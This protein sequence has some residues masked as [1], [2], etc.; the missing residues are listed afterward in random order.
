M[1]LPTRLPNEQMQQQWKSQLDPVLAIPMLQ[2]LQ[3]KGVALKAGV[4]VVNTLL[5]RQQQGWM[6]TD[7]DA[8]AKVYRSQP[9]NTLTLTLTS[10]AACNVN[11]WVY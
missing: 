8:P 3:L 6:I 11:L 9:F 5:G 10:D 2:G 4:N 1:G 7:I